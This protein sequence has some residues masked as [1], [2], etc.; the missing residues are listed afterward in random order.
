MPAEFPEE[1]MTEALTKG[2]RPLENLAVNAPYLAACLNARP[3]P[4]GVEEP[5]TLVQGWAGSPVWPYP[6]LLETSDH[7]MLVSEVGMSE[8][9]DFT[10]ATPLAFYDAS[11]PSTSNTVPLGGG[12]WALAD[13]GKDFIFMTNNTSVV[14]KATHLKK[15]NYVC[16]DDVITP[17]T[18][19]KFGTALVLGGAVIGTQIPVASRWYEFMDNM[20]KFS[21]ANK[22]TNQYAGTGAVTTAEKD[23]SNRI[24]WSRTSKDAQ[25]PFAMFLAMFHIA[26]AS[27]HDILRE[28]IIDE[29][30][31]ANIGFT[32]LSQSGEILFMA[33]LGD[34]LY[35]YTTSGISV[36]NS[37]MEEV[38]IIPIEAGNRGCV[39]SVGGTHYI[40]TTEQKLIKLTS[41]GPELLD[42]SEFLST[43]FLPGTH[44]SY[45]PVKGELYI[46]DSLLTYVYGPNGLYEIAQR[47][48]SV[49]RRGTTLHA[50]L[51]TPGS[52]TTMELTS[53]HFDFNVSDIKSLRHVDLYARDVVNLVVG[54]D[55]R[56]DTSDA[57]ATITA[58]GGSPEN[59]F[60]PPC[61]GVEFRIN[62]EGDLSSGGVI[63][64]VRA[65]IMYESGRTTRGPR[66]NKTS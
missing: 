57:F 21:P 63:Q 34:N 40:I 61:G 30:R 42:Y 33:P 17:A 54:T 15:D 9:D 25:A 38:A 45:D 16:Q 62:I 20:V 52:T 39:H 7:V 19:A 51:G 22:V 46:G 26:G 14:V 50:Q 53:H 10:T 2:L 31:T 58:I 60:F 41:E 49:L 18:C 23:N 35:V 27:T 66:G 32:Q 3:T 59:I 1:I 48:T 6:M 8:V 11:N 36:I 44:M 29:I 56:F 5:E 24:F 4:S 12:K 47:P 65:R 55:Y 13:F 37:N 28:Y 43:L 64:R